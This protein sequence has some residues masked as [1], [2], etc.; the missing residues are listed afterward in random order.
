MLT[1]LFLRFI[2]VFIL[3]FYR[4]ARIALQTGGQT[5]AQANVQIGVRFGSE[6]IENALKESLTTGEVVWLRN[7]RV[8][9]KYCN[10]NL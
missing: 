5:N 10:S 3:R 9:G 8:A 2:K 1:L 7:N 4:F 6:A